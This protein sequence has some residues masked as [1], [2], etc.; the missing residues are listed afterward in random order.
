MGSK[1]LL[2]YYLTPLWMAKIKN[3]STGFVG[4]DVESGEQSLT[5]GWIAKLYSH[6][7]N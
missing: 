7:E 3:M 1:Q 5:A 2:S 6:F 4:E